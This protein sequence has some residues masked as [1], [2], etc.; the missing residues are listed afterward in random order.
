L[1]SKIEGF[2]IPLIESMSMGCPVVAIKQITTR[3]V[4]G[5]A[6]LECNACNP[7]DVAFRIEQVMMD[8]ELRAQ[9]RAPGLARANELDWSRLAGEYL[10]LFKQFA[11]RSS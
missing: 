2:S 11:G 7:A 8:T 10:T 6:A 5:V 3:E 1:T 9:M 4:C